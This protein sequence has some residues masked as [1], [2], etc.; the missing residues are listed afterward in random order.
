MSK[1]F[2]IFRVFLPL[3]FL[4]FA[5][6][7]LSAKAEAGAREQTRLVSDTG[8]FNYGKFLLKN[9]EFAHA[10]R[11]FLRVIVR[12]PD[13]PLVEEA[14]LKIG[15]ARFRA[16][17]YA[18]AKISFESFLSKYKDSEFSREVNFAL[19]KTGKFLREKAK[20]KETP[21]ELKRIKLREKK[22]MRAVQVLLFEGRTIGQVR[23]EIRE[24]KK[25]GVDTII[26]RVFHNKGDRRYHFLSKEGA[27][28]GVYFKTKHAPL[29]A[30]VLGKIL[31]I[32]HSEGI[33]VFAWMTTRY[34]DY[35][36]EDRADLACLGY[37]LERRALYRCKGL[38]VF[39]ERAL[40]HLENLYRDLAAYD[41][42][43]ILFQDDLVLRHNEGFGKSADAFFIR[44]GATGIIPE[45]LYIRSEGSTKV[46]YT[47]NFWRW[48]ELK[49][50][51]LLEVAARLKRVAR[52]ENPDLEFAINFMYESV[53]S[54][55]NALAWLSQDLRMARKVGFD[56]YSI[57]AYHRQMG[58]EL[59]KSRG[60]VFLMI[61][62]MA[63]E[64]ALVVGDPEQVLMKIQTIDWDSGER[65]SR[66]ELT[67][68][69][70]GVRGA[71]VSIA[72]VPYRRG[73]PLAELTKSVKQRVSKE[74]LALQKNRP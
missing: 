54:P 56:Y 21:P 24:L 33:R 26:L 44:K 50:K 1:N 5:L 73:L 2:K 6:L 58:K 64:A 38:D 52:G 16:K 49:N 68:L 57:M 55:T 31:N 11:E 27:L 41:I 34:A 46:Q 19:L 67:S 40:K 61:K 4:I 37:D 70:R 12:F 69:V 65:L 42:D 18:L 48:V 17:K 74:H 9:K 72:F 22:G 29:I 66:T 71:G 36:I 30:D 45:D 15:I 32:A 39:N 63:R 51:R 14:E 3:I 8:Q 47:E 59:G 62:K 53:I 10:E 43:G 23:R 60:E 28:T 25:S 20:K 35:G 13:S 7:I